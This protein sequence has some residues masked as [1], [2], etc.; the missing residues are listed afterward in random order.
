M[1]KSLLSIY[2]ISMLLVTATSWSV[3]AES[4][5]GYFGFEPDI[6]TNYIGQGNK[7]LGYVRITVDLMLNDLSDIAIVEH[8][9]P[10][11]RDAIVEILSKEPE[12]NIKSLTGREEIRKRCTE[13]LKA[14]LKQETGQE[15]VREVLFTK[16]LYH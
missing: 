6:I 1:K 16:Y 2:L 4:N 10:L 13:K 9:T 5:V 14:L 8:H 11:L 3:R 15:I 7:K 12:E